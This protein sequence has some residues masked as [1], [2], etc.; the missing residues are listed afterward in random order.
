MAEEKHEIALKHITEIAK[1]DNRLVTQSFA[2]FSKSWGAFDLDWWAVLISQAVDHK[3]NTIKFS[4]DQVKDLMLCNRRTH[5]SLKG[6]VKRSNKALSK[7]LDIKL[8]FEQ[9]SGKDLALYTTHMF[10]TSYIDT[11]LNV[12]LKIS[13]AAQPV[14]NQLKTWT[15]FAVGKLAALHTTYSKRLFI[16]LKQWRTIGKVSFKVDDFRDKMDVPKSYRPGSIDQKILEPALEDLA[17]YFKQLRV[18]KTYTKAKRGRKLSGY[19]F[20]FKPETKTQQDIYSKDLDDFASVYSIVSNRYLSL[21][22]KLRAIDRYRELRLGTTQKYYEQVHPQT[23][24]LDGEHKDKKLRYNTGVLAKQSITGL[25]QLAEAYERLLMTGKLKE[26]DLDD[27]IIIEK[28]L[29]L[30]QVQL[31]LETKGKEHPYKPSDSLIAAQVIKSLPD[32][33]SYDQHKIDAEIKR[34]VHLNY[35]K[36]VRQEDH[37]PY[38]FRKKDRL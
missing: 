36:F 35:G 6:F 1:L 25:K 7:F 32:I 23:I 18:E 9:Q 15:R 3:D 12:I 24:F 17:P 34:L 28:Q 20:I 21:K 30:K 37:R 38:E 29:F 4:V 16:Y 11:D 14:F 31:I 5:E 26:W 27:L 8:T 2:N 10:D 33:A 19:V 13:S 22:R